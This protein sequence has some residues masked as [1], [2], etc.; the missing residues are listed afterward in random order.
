ML[1]LLFRSM[2]TFKIG[3]ELLVFTDGDNVLCLG[4][5]VLLSTFLSISEIKTFFS[6]MRVF[7]LY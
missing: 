3:N 5:C 7:L 2:R 4:E 1:F 6:Q